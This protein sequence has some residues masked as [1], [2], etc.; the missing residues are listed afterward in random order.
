[1]DQ[2][3]SFLGSQEGHRRPLWG[4]NVK[5]AKIDLNVQKMAKIDPF[6]DPSFLKIYILTLNLINLCLSQIRGKVPKKWW[7]FMVNWDPKTRISHCF[8]QEK[9]TC[10]RR[11]PGAERVFQN[12]LFWDPEPNL[13]TTIS[14]ASSTSLMNDQKMDVSWKR[15]VKNDPKKHKKTVD[16][17]KMGHF[18]KWHFSRL[19]PNTRR[20][21]KKGV[22]KWVKNPFLSFLARDR[23]SPSRNFGRFSVFKKWIFS[24]S[25]I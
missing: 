25:C 19:K 6:L 16:F 8:K 22:K 21:W 5:M 12:P 9:N 7:F 18:L 14:L 17:G 1:M 10:F 13:T 2:K 11:F 15:V 3:W 23:F 4:P 20:L 24:F